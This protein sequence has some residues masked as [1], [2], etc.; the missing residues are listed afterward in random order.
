MPISVFLYAR[1]STQRQ[2]DRD[3]SIPDQLGAMTKFAEAEGWSIA[4]TFIDA[5]VSGGTDR[6]REFQKMI[7][8]AKAGE[9]A[10]NL[11]MVHSYSRLFR[12]SFLA[13]KYRL[14]LEEHDVR[15]HDVGAVGWIPHADE[16]T[17]GFWIRHYCQL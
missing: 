2:A 14:E 13:E 9:P 16:M 15:L 6:R 1:V 3:L 7:K 10:V 12:N 17:Q 4:G 8:A 11:I 5:G